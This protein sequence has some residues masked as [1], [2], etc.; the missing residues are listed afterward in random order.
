MSTLHELPQLCQTLHCFCMLLPWVG[1][2]RPKAISGNHFTHWPTRG[3]TKVPPKRRS[4]IVV[5]NIFPFHFFSHSF[6]P[7]N[8]TG[9]QNILALW[10]LVHLS[11][12]NMHIRFLQQEP[13][14]YLSLTNKKLCFSSNALYEQANRRI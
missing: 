14:A 8:G 7:R 5:V 4:R 2:I 12:G 1:V 10:F 3:C 11:A 9:K 6:G 13:N